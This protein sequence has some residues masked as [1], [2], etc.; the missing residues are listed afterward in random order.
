MRGQGPRPVVHFL[1]FLVQ[2]G[3][4]VDAPGRCAAVVVVVVLGKVVSGGH[5]HSSLRRVAQK[6]RK[7][8][9]A[10][11]ESRAQ[12]EIRPRTR[13][14]DRLRW[15]RRKISFAPRARLGAVGLRLV[16]KRIVSRLFFFSYSLFRDWSVLFFFALYLVW[17]LFG[18]SGRLGLAAVL[19]VASIGTRVDRLL[20]ALSGPVSMIESF[21]S[22]T[23]GSKWS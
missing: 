4:L 9:W 8:R 18:G 16:L 11:S 19:S 7:G 3:L 22:A 17:I 5:L 1:V 2:A 6:T 14:G 10:N 15:T 13:R 20:P 12:P 23:P 21:V